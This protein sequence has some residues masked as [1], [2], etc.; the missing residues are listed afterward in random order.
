MCWCARRTRSPLSGAGD[1]A[2]LHAS[3][4]IAHLQVASW[5]ASEDRLA[6]CV[7]TTDWPT[8][9]ELEEMIASLEADVSN[10]GPEEQ[11]QVLIVKGALDRSRGGRR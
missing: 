10:N 5:E 3:V 11:T 4:V 9:V 8:G 7:L 6:E 1:T 2:L